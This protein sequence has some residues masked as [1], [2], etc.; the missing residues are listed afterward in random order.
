VCVREREG[1]GRKVVLS[2]ESVALE[3]RYG[4]S[5]AYL[6]EACHIFLGTV[7][8]QDIASSTDNL[9]CASAVSDRQ[10]KHWSCWSHPL[11]DGGKL[12]L[13]AGAQPS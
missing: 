13:L 10:S 2:V 3:G 5:H 12:L 7:G 9:Q 1:G 4:T 6:E 11:S 8:A